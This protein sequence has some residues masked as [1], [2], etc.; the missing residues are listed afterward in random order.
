[1]SVGRDWDSWSVKLWARNVFDE[2]Y[3]VRGFFFGNEPPDFPPTLYTRLGD[4]RHYG[5]TLSYQ[6]VGAAMRVTAE[7]SLYPL[8]GQ[9]LE[10]ILAFIEA[11]AS[12]A[13]LEVVVNQMSTQVRGELGVVMG[14]IDGGDRALVRRRRRAGARA[15]V[16]ER[17]FADRR[18]AG[19]RAAVA[20][21]VDVVGACVQQLSPLEAAG[22]LFAFSYLVL[23]IRENLWCWP[24]A[25]LSSVLHVARLVRRAALLG[26]GAERFLRRD[27]GLRL[28]PVALRRRARAA[29]AELPIG[30][31]PLKTHA[32]AIGGSVALSAVLGWL[33]SRHTTPR[34]RISMRS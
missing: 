10:K 31:W 27:G 23:A 26:V 20:R 8:Q 30:V 11:I 19:S 24:A 7:M 15:E 29:R 14:T 5:I 1:M 16:P 33:M 13:R 34:S 17:R 32:L 3:F 21:A 25:F 4:P 22:V 28:V 12:D 9:P 18:A 2:D 6:I